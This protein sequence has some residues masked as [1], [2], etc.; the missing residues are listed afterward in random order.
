VKI[1]IA[2]VSGS[3]KTTI[4]KLVAEKLGCEFADAD[5]FHP[6]EN[7]AKMGAGIPLDDADRAGWLEA[8]GHHLAGRDSIVLACSALKKIYRDR[9]RELAGR[10]RF[11]VLTADRALLE[12]RLANREHFMPG[13]LLDS[14]LGTLELGDDV[15]VVENSADPAEVASHVASVYDRR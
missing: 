4:G 5:D 9:L 6:P 2:G 7:I 8:L 12:E 10:I 3:G 15:E 1:V 13:S 11:F 14:Q